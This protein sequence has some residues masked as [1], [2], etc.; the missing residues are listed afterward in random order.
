MSE[1]EDP[2][3][4][5]CQGHQE[6]DRLLQP[7]YDGGFGAGSGKLLSRMHAIVIAMLT[8]LL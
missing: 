7:E 6:Q 8:V 4:C 3:G 5:G 2:R 1:P